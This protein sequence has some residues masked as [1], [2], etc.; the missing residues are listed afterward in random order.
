MDLSLA[1][2]EVLEALLVQV[3]PVR[4]AQIAK[5]LNKEFPAVQMHLIGLVKMGYAASPQKGYY[6]ISENGKKALGLE[7]TTKDKAK[8]IVSQVSED[9]AFHFYEDIGKPLHL[10]AHDLLEFCDKVNKMQAESVKF[11]VDRGDFEA[12]FKSLGDDELVLKT[13]LLKNKKLTVDELRSK[14]LKIAESRCSELSK[15]S[16]IDKVPT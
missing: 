15:K 10:Y 2:T 14:L 16:G 8:K 11:H 1:K 4:G 6:L 13:S 12:W 7:E 9:K 3:E 5:E